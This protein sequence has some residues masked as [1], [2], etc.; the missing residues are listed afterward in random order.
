M[1]RFGLM[2]ILYQTI[3]KTLLITY[4]KGYNHSLWLPFMPL[5]KNIQVDFQWWYALWLLFD[6]Y[7]YVAE[8]SPLGLI[9]YGA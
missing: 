6:D 5:S 8:L 9:D 1:D 4:H 3:S 7:G 2:N